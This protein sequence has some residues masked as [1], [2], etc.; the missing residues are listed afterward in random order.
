[1]RHEHSRTHVIEPAWIV[2]ACC[3]IAG[4]QLNEPPGRS[5]IQHQALGAMSLRD[6]WKAAPVSSAPIQ[7]NW[8]ATFDDDQLS[9]LVAEAL[10]HNLDLQIAAT[11]VEQAALYVN[12]AEAAL[13]PAI[14]VLGTGGLK[15]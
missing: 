4:C 2:C 5:D 13:R 15:M 14:G 12:L 11:R 3:V 1:M 9:A 10:D 8:L 6:P 7:D